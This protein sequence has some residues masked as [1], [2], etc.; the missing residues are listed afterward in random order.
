MSAELEWSI[1]RKIADLQ[2]F[3]TSDGCTEEDRVEI[4]AK[5]EQVLEVVNRSKARGSTC[6]A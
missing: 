6:E 3:L 5:L 1:R 2:I 4:D